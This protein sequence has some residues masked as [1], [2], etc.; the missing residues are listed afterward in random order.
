M[1]R[2]FIVVLLSVLWGVSGVEI[3][4]KNGIFVL[5]NSRLT[6]EISPVHGGR[7]IR[8]Y[9]K[10]TK[11][12]LTV[13]P[14]NGQVVMDSGL[15]VDRVW[16]AK[17]ETQARHYEN[18]AY[19]VV[20]FKADKKRGEL[21]LRCQS[22]PLDIEKTYILN[23]NERTLRVRY[24]LSNP[25]DQAFTGRFWVNNVVTPD[26]DTWKINFPE[27]HY[28]DDLSKPGPVKQPVIVYNKNTPAGG[29]HWSVSPRKDYAAV[30]GRRSGA[31]IVAS[32][33]FLECFYSCIPSRKGFPPTLEWMT[34]NLY[35]KPLSVG[36]ADAVNHPE[37]EDPLQDYI[38][39]FEATVSAFDKIDF[40]S[41]R[42]LAKG[43]K[44]TKFRQVL[45]G[46]KVYNEFPYPSVPWFSE[47]KECPKVLIFTDYMNSAQA[48]DFFRRFRCEAE[49]AEGW[50][51][52][53]LIPDTQY[54]GY[55]V[56]EPKQFA[57]KALQ[58]NPELI[59]IPNMQNNTFPAEVKKLL[60]DRVKAGAVAISI[61]DE[62]RFTDL[63]SGKGKKVPSH[64]FRGLPLNVTVTEHPVGKGKV[65]YVPFRLY[66]NYRP[67]S[68]P[69]VFLPAPAPELADPEPYYA[70]YCRLFR[71]ALN[72]TSPA[73]ILRADVREN[74]IEAVIRSQKSAS[75]ELNGKKISLQSGEN[76]VV[77]PFTREK[78]NGSYNVPLLL[79]VN[80][81]S[82]DLFIPRYEVKQ[83]PHFRSFA[84]VRYAHENEMPVAGNFEVAGS[85]NVRIVLRDAADRVL[86]LYE[87]N[88]VS[89]KGH[90]SI[91]PQLD[92]IN[93]YC[94]LTAELYG[95]NGLVE[96][97]KKVVSRRTPD[98]SRLRFVLWHSSFTAPADHIRNLGAM[99]MGF[100]HLMSSQVT[101]LGTIDA[102]HGAEAIQRA[103]GRYIV[104]TLYRFY[105]KNLQKGH[106]KFRDPCIHDPAEMKK[107]RAYVR[108]I[109]SKH[110]ANFPVSYYSAD[111]NGLGWHEMPHDLC[112]NPH[113]LKA[114]R[115][116]MQK[117]YGSLARLNKEWK[118]S[119]KSWDAVMP[120]TQKE[121]RQKE[122]F[123]PWLAHRLFM[124][125][126][127]DTGMSGLHA[128]LLSVDPKAKMGHSGQGL[129]RVEDCWDWRVMPKFYTQSSIYA[130]DGGG[131]QDLLRTRDPKYP[132][133]NWNGYQ[134]PLPQIRYYCW[135]DIVDGMFC[136]SYWTNNF[137]FRRGDNGLNE[138][139][140]HMKGVIRE[141]KNSGA[142][143]LMT[144]G[145]RVMS[146][147]TLVYSPDSLIIAAATGAT[148]YLDNLVYTHNFEGWTQLIR[149]AGFPAPQAIGDDKLSGVTAENTRCLILPMLQMMTDSQIA[150][151][152]KYVEDG[153][154]LVIDAQA[155]LFNE[156]YLQRSVNP[157][158]K[159]AGV[160]ATVAKGTVDGT[161]LFGD[162]PV[163]FSVTG[164]KAAPA[165][166]HAE[167]SV[168]ISTPRA[169]FHTI[170]LG[171]VKRPISGAFFIRK[172]GKGY[173]I[174]LN[175]L[176]DR[177]VSKMADPVQM[178]SMI[179]VFRN[180]F[181]KVEIYPVASGACGVNHS[182]YVHS[183]YRIFTV[184]RRGGPGEETFV[185]PLNDTYQLYDTL[186]HKYMGESDKVEYKLK[187]WEVGSCIAVQEKLEK[188]EISV[189]RQKDGITLKSGSNSGVWC[190]EIFCNG[191]AV[192][193]I[194]RNVVLDFEN[195]EFFA[196]GITPSGKYE[197]RAFNILNGE[198]LKWE[199]E[200][201]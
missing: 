97:Q 91:K 1:K 63:F 12:E 103:G 135:N 7:V 95:K 108:E 72:Y 85:G 141:V 47:Q 111:E 110:T 114:F 171:E 17:G 11:M 163:H 161:L 57:I 186:H 190:V 170:E 120:F 128:E 28:S 109:A 134:M 36:K 82:A 32:F 33:E 71:Y 194:A 167:G 157:L 158:M 90:F 148:S 96:R 6:V 37:L 18:T 19:E 137:F 48:F 136:P 176:F 172:A 81:F 40:A 166:A 107:I 142:D 156:F 132:A 66:L 127:L 182:E 51:G 88:N 130:R 93:S 192:K 99:E 104:N 101:A 46:D 59:I 39:R 174:Y 147:F 187:A 118:T 31:A 154:I 20:Q 189:L 70:F 183:R 26:G 191:K 13:A 133:G 30:S 140:L 89:G 199:V 15:F 178:R 195:N 175:V 24:A 145:E 67:W 168:S 181:E 55:S 8:F 23:E 79:K 185:Y 74:Q 139:G 116:A 164:A 122:N 62:N 61:T 184:S 75:A 146:P 180:L 106:S 65:F 73:E 44:N 38:V 201:K 10:K 179:S 169:V 100:T 14:A 124:L 198:K 35:I 9:D 113:T 64:V 155:G 41:Y 121:A 56:P 165:G 22:R 159:L 152:K 143:P 77:L 160:N 4:N 125:T 105:S 153:G 119:F 200:Y 29:N 149:S 197:V 115:K 188:P 52:G 162:T 3:V 25:A 78:L 49:V 173:V 131:L 138:E 151:V 58:N 54:C 92:G 150:H 196:L 112:F 129:T 27:G 83:N 193:G 16:P 5:S 80:G 144:C 34:S 117:K 2:F 177:V 84:P 21:Q 42:P 94:T 102:R 50:R 68:Q 76:K 126:A 60:I 86:G 69:W 43:R 45:S 87:K 98:H 123:V 53:I